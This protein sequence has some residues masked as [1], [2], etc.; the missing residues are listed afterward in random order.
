[1]SKHAVLNNI[2]HKDLKVITRR[3]QELGDAVMYSHIY[4]YE[5]RHIQA[6]YPIV[7]SRDEEN[8][9]YYALALFGFEEGE[10]LYLHDQNTQQVYLPILM[11]RGPFLIGF[12]KD[13][14]GNLVDKKMVISI[15][16]ENPRLSKT[17][18][19][20][21]FLPHGGHSDFTE[22]IITILQAIHDGQSIN[23]EFVDSVSGYDLFEP[24]NLDVT[25]DNNEMH[26]LTGF[27]TINEQKLAELPVDA[28]AELNKSGAL[29]GIY[30]VLASLSNLRKLI[31]RKNN[32]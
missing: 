7:F 18:G 6:D 5:F 26:R 22:S 14:S 10:N 30:M 8:N 29:Q 1:M 16:L 4:P 15:D 19:E 28:I 31:E 25:L 13:A 2:Q 23:K 27:Y 21:L 11:Q 32:S 20:A 9:T 3:S 24:F 17:E 12:Q